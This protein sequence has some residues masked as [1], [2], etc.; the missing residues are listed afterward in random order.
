MLLHLLRCLA[1]GTSTEFSRDTTICTTQNTIRKCHSVFPPFF[2]VLLRKWPLEKK[3]NKKRARGCKVSLSDSKCVCVCS[4]CVCV[5]RIVST[6]RPSRLEGP[7]RLVGSTSTPR[8]GEKWGGKKLKRVI[9][10]LVVKTFNFCM[11]EKRARALR[12][13]CGERTPHKLFLPRVKNIKREKKGKKR[14]TLG[15]LFPSTQ[16]CI[17]TGRLRLRRRRR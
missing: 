17:R 15:F 7:S 3:E 10:T 2:F 16:V 11:Q 8:R 5:C 12:C 13:D 1:L 6:G 4:P 14:A 9:C